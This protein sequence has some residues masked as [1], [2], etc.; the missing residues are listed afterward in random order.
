MT[1]R[2]V[3]GAF[4]LISSISFSATR[5]AYVSYSTFAD[6]MSTHNIIEVTVKIQNISANTQTITLPATNATNAN[7]VNKIYLSA[8]SFP[9][10]FTGGNSVKYIKIPSTG[11]AT[12]YNS[13]GDTDISP[14]DSILLIYAINPKASVL[15]A[16]FG[17]KTSLNSSG[18]TKDAYMYGGGD[19]VSHI[20][21]SG[22][23]KIRDRDPTQIGS[24]IISGSITKPT[25]ING[26]T[27]SITQSFAIN[28]GKPL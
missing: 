13:S 23:I 21:A 15:P 4:F 6:S 25:V 9:G 27:T 5:S 12:L 22:I 1:A 8:N 18:N 28:E 10:G 11:V 17:T 20:F 14:G 26:A 16:I 7:L 19:F 3:L 2:I 24:V